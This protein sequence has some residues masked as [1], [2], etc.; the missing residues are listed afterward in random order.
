MKNRL[1]EFKYYVEQDIQKY[2]CDEKIKKELRYVLLDG[3]NIRAMMLLV[4]EKNYKK[5][6]PVALAIEMIHNYSLIHDDLPC[7]DDDDMRRGK[8]TL[9]KRLG[10]GV[11][12]LIGDAL[13]THAFE[14]II[15]S[16]FSEIDKLKILKLL[17]NACGI[18]EGMILGQYY[19]INNLS[20]YNE[21]E[22]LNINNQKTGKMIALPLEIF[23]YTNSYDIEK[24]KKV[25]LLIGELYQI[26]DDYF[27]KY[28][29]SEIIGK[30]INKDIKNGK[31]T[32]VEF[33]SKKEVELKIIELETEINLLIVEF[34]KEHILY[35]QKIMKRKY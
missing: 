8:P 24:Y 7:M 17:I 27:D 12:L 21:I 22:L 16:D 2:K 13:L 9:H 14:K 35:I 19:D 30:E 23:A 31:K 34:N 4:G 10:E 29:T 28:K 26:Q 11:A 6:F 25:G 20:N 18:N 5:F 32:F 1:D 33:Y 15:D 3:K